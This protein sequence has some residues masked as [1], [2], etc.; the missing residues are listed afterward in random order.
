MTNECL[1]T[2]LFVRVGFMFLFAGVGFLGTVDAVGSMESGAEHFLLALTVATTHGLD[3]IVK[4]GFLGFL[5]HNTAETTKIVPSVRASGSH[6]R[7]RLTAACHTTLLPTQGG[8][9]P[10][11]GARPLVWDVEQ[12]IIARVP[13]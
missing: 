1:G 5:F 12:W 7:D 4:T 2:L 6:Y 9:L 10:W 11:C 8:G 13:S 3:N